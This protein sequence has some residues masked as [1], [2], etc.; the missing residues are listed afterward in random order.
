MDYV[1]Y[2]QTN[3]TTKINKIDND[4]I[5]I[6][7]KCRTTVG[8]EYTENIPT[9]EFK[10]RLLKSEHSPIRLLTVDWS[11]PSIKSWVAT[12]FSRHKWECFISTRRSDRTGVDRSTLSQDELVQFDGFANAQN[13]ID[14]ARKRLC[15]CASTETRQ[16]MEDLKIKITDREKELGNVLVPNCVYRAGCPEFETCGYWKSFQIKHGNILNIDERY[17]CYNSDFEERMVNTYK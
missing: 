13:L 2:K 3:L 12:H 7:N 5:N 15:F 1:R 16:R 14:T 8:K 6:K 4:W 11:W 9:S 10:W 17:A